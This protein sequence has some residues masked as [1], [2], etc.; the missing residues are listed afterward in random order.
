M[1]NI[2]CRE[3]SVLARLYGCYSRLYIL[4]AVHVQTRRHKVV[5]TN[6]NDLEKWRWSASLSFG[7]NKINFFAKYDLN[8]LF[9]QDVYTTDGSLLELRPLQFGFIFYIL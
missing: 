6:I 1:A 8:N 7:Y 3:I 4:V 9:K 2:H 5:I